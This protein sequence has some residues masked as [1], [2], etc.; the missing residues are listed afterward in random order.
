MIRAFVAVRLPE[1]LRRRLAELQK[2]LKSVLPDVR[3]V[4]PENIHLTL[5]F[6]GNTGPEALPSFEEALSAVAASRVPFE[7]AVEGIGVFPERRRPR[8]IWAGITAGQEEIRSL[9]GAVE[10]E[11]ARLGIARENRRFHPHLTI[12][13]FRKPAGGIGEIPGIDLQEPLGSFPVDVI[14]LF[15]SDLRPDGARYRLLGRYPLAGGSGRRAGRL[16]NHNS[17]GRSRRRD[18]QDR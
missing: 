4:P 12:G 2:N 7:A 16:S 14:G 6:L 10:Q 11:T 18:D 3:W 15:Q 1:A 8:V 5:K 13:R 17:S 9:A